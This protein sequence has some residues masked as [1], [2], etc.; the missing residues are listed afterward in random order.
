MAT[1]NIS[2]QEL[3]TVAM[4]LLQ[5][6]NGMKRTV[7]S[8]TSKLASMQSWSDPRAQ[9]FIQQSNMI[10]KGL[11]LN[12]ANFTKMAE[13]LKKYAEKQEEMDRQM[14]QNIINSG[15]KK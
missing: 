2:T 14:R 12:I 13:F 15:P 9:Q 6:A 7:S 1:V 5:Q 4:N 8:I 11:S 3:I 10:C